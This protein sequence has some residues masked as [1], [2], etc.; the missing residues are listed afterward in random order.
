MGTNLDKEL[1]KITSENQFLKQ[2]IEHLREDSLASKELKEKVLKYEK[3]LT[4]IQNNF[5]IK[6]VELTQTLSEVDKLK[7][8]KKELNLLIK[9]QKLS[10]ENLEKEPVAPDRRSYWSGSLR[11]GTGK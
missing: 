10:I 11:S 6:K 9:N 8:E 5:A 1:N 7:D 3:T 2:E 4:E